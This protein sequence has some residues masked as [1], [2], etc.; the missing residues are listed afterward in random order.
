MVRYKYYRP[1]HVHTVQPSYGPVEGGMSV[2]VIGK[3]FADGPSVRCRFGDAWANAEARSSRLVVCIVPH[4][5]RLGNVTIGVS[6]NGGDHD[7]SDFV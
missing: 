6:N 2:T 5:A 7:R 4:T 3:G 1:E